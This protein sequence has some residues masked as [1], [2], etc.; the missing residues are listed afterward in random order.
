[1]N[2]RGKVNF[3]IESVIMID[4][5]KNSMP[6]RNQGNLFCLGEKKI[7]TQKSKPATM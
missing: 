6:I 1:M 2:I 4:C 7:H 3:T 5:G